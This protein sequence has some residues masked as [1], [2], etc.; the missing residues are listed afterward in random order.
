[1]PYKL[2][3]LKYKIPKKS[4]KLLLYQEMLPTGKRRSLATSHNSARSK[5]L[6]HM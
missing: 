3:L 5:K 1:M 6:Q 2:D 4:T